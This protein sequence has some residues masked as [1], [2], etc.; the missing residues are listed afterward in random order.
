ME[1][2]SNLLLAL[3]L[4]ALPLAVSPGRTRV[5]VRIRRPRVWLRL[6]CFAGLFLS[7][8]VPPALARGRAP[9]SPGRPAT[10]SLPW[11]G[12]NG[13]PP[14]RPFVRTEELTH[15]TGLHM[16][17]RT[18]REVHGVDTGATPVSR[19]RTKILSP[20]TGTNVRG[21]WR[22]IRQARVSML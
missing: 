8:V 3:L 17:A 10:A 9:L 19:A 5:R 15:G 22:P 13:S 20:P 7:T 2:T 18:T 21:Q 14:P 4:A 16:T 6:S 1:I 11:S 12:A